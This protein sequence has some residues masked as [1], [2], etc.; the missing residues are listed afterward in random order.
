MDMNRT[1]GRWACL[2]AVV[3]VA[4]LAPSRARAQ[5]YKPAPDALNARAE[6]QLRGLFAARNDAS[7]RAL[8]SGGMLVCGPFLW[9][10]LRNAP[11]LAGKGTQSMFVTD[12][13]ADPQHVSL[14]GGATGRMFMAKPDI[15]AFRQ[16]FLATYPSDP[17]AKVRKLRMA[18]LRLFAAMSPFPPQEP[19]F[20]VETGAHRFIVS[21]DD[22]LRIGWI[23]DY[24]HL[25]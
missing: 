1:A 18:E 19:L 16:A 21:L 11:A 17:R 12:T 25:P 7:S 24:L 22:H 8:F 4:A 14:T 13:G 5:F 3:A 15:A 2:T 23:D 20:V 9:R 10:N 6:R